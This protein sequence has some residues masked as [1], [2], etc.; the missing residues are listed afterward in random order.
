MSKPGSFRRWGSLTAQ[1]LRPLV[2]NLKRRRQ[3]REA[4]RELPAGV[5]G[6]SPRSLTE[7]GHMEGWSQTSSDQTL[8]SG[9][10]VVDLS[11]SDRPGTRPSR[12]H[13]VA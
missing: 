6:D 1:V 13:T 12:P 9:G 10:T 11:P 4:P 7:N 5:A 2:A 3:L 8:W